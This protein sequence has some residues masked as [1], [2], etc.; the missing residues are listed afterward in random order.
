MVSAAETSAKDIA[1]N[2]LIGLMNESFRHSK[3]LTWCQMYFA[4]KVRG[5][6]APQTTS[7]HFNVTSGRL[8]M[9]ASHSSADHSPWPTASAKPT[10]PDLKSNSASAAVPKTRARFSSNSFSQRATTTVAKQLPITFT[11]V[12]PMSINSSTPK[13]M[14][15]PTGPSPDGTKEFNTASKM[16]SAALGTPATPL[17]LTINV[18]I[19]VICWPKDM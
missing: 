15:T 7:N 16:T 12:R 17:E 4:E 19:I 11:Q 1:K 10:L 5:R 9:D 2:F 14:A 8:T 3:M 18:S 6:S 13:I